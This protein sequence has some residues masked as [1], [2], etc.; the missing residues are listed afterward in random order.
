MLLSFKL[1]SK[2]DKLSPFSIMH[3]STSDL[4]F[5]R[6]RYGL[7][8]NFGFLSFIS[9][10]SRREILYKNPLESTKRKPSAILP[11]AFNF[12]TFPRSAELVNLGMIWFY[13]EVNSQ[14][15]KFEQPINRPRLPRLVTS[16]F[17]HS[18]QLSPP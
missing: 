4:Y 6:R 1:Q 16:L 3:F 12:V 17:E 13:E 5:G 15:G 11:V 14:C 8:V 10:T 9:E 18:G 2:S 7:S